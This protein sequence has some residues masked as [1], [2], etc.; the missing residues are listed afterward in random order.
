MDA[1]LL[2]DLRASLERRRAELLGEGSVTVAAE[3]PGVPEKPDEDAQPLEEMNKVIASNRNRERAERLA[4]IDA[5]LARMADDPDGFGDCEG[6]G[7][8]IAR[9][10]LELMPWT[11]LCIECQAAQEQNGAPGGRRH[12]TDYR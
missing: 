7:E 9:K 6:C 4:E 12:I 3:H 10:R 2:A 8:A 11:R 5:A 1:R